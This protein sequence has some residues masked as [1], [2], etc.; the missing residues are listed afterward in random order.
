MFGRR[1]MGVLKDITRVNRSIEV[2]GHNIFLPAKIALR[3]AVATNFSS[4]FDM[5]V[6][7]G[8]I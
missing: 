5:E 8:K 4:L 2:I 3:A 6:V 1:P 7:I